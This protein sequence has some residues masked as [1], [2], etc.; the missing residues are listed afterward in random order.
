M[1]SAPHGLFHSSGSLWYGRS[2]AKKSLAAAATAAAD[3]ERQ[4]AVARQI[5]EKDWVALRAL[6]LGDQYPELD[7][8]TRIKMAKQEKRERNERPSE[9]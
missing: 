3:F 6:A 7:V 4:M 5:M 1:P 8:D 9:N 2:M